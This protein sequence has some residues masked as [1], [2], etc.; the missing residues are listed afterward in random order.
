MLA[1]SGVAARVISAPSLELLRAQPA[2][3]RERLL[4]PGVPHVGV[5][6]TRGE[7]L[8][9]LL[10]TGALVVAL[11]RFGAS[12][13]YQVLA[14]HFGFAPAALAARVRSFLGR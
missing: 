14:E 3:Y 5:E 1:E 13:P 11:D 9:A 2:E 8:R 12:A 6:A 4:E 7:A 10:G